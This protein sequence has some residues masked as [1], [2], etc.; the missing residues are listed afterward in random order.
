MSSL[1]DLK[2]TSSNFES[3]LSDY[4]EGGKCFLRVIEAS[5]RKL[6]VNWI[7]RLGWI[8]SASILAASE[9]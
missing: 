3:P 1:T 8:D 4:S 2:L 9:A 6:T 5:Q 7:V